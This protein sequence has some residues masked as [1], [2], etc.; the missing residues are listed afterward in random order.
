MRLLISC[1]R[2][3][4]DYLLRQML[5][6]IFPL[7]YPFFM[8]NIQQFKRDWGAKKCKIFF[9]TSRILRKLEMFFF[10]N[11]QLEYTKLEDLDYFLNSG[12][13]G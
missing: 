8:E 1:C 13:C 11:F 10:F 5:G 9:K 3:R 6:L 12:L 4:I 7:A 2:L